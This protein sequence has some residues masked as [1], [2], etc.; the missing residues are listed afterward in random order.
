MG[1][2]LTEFENLQMTGSS[3]AGASNNINH[4][5]FTYS[6]IKIYLRLSESRCVAR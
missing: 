4:C 3:P 5:G 6:R 1:K 2:N